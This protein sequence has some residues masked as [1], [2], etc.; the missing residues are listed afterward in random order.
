MQGEKMHHK[1]RVNI[2]IRNSWQFKLT[3]TLFLFDTYV[4]ALENYV[5]KHEA[6]TV[7]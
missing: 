3:L 2:L 4:N 7:N 1:S 6:T 5:L